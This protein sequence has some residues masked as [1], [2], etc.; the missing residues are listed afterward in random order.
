MFV[1][2]AKKNLF[3]LFSSQ[4]KYYLLKGVFPNPLNLRYPLFLVTLAYHHF[5]LSSQNLSLSK[6]SFFIYLFV[7]VGS[8]FCDGTS[9]L[10][11]TLSLVAAVGSSSLCLCSCTQLCQTLCNPMDCSPSGSSIHVKVKLLSRVQLFATPWIA[12]YHRKMSTSRLYIVT[13]LI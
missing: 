11:Y 12:A 10:R 8:W 13:L 1:F 7:C 2:P 4:F 5:K 3:W 6:S 9:S